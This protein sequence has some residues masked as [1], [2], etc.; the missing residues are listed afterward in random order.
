MF[1]QLGLKKHTIASSD[2]QGIFGV[3]KS[4]FLVLST[5]EKWLVPAVFL[6]VTVLLVKSI[7]GSSLDSVLGMPRF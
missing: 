7:T 5:L 3:G 4:P 2:S 6:R 1:G